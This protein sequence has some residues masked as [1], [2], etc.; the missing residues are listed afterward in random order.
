MF[1]SSV[2][3][4]TLGENEKEEEM[5]KIVNKELLSLVNVLLHASYQFIFLSSLSKTLKMPGTPWTTMKKDD[6]CRDGAV[7]ILDWV[8]ANSGYIELADISRPRF[9]E[10]E[11][12]S[13]FVFRRWD[14]VEKWIKR[15][16]E[17][18]RE[19]IKETDYDYEKNTDIGQ[20]LNN[21]LTSIMSRFYN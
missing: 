9:E 8:K 20:V 5:N 2:K 3:K 16:I 7:I 18:T 15:N 10:S 4:Q 21:I 14:E 17:E 12:N 13:E 6:K 1:D 19:K 11:I